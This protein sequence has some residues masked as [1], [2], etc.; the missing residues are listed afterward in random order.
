[1]PYETSRPAVLVVADEPLLLMLYARILESAGFAVWPAENGHAAV[2]RLAEPEIR[3]LFV[4]TDLKMAPEGN[5]DLGRY[6]AERLPAL[7]V[8]HVSVGPNGPGRLGT[9][10]HLGYFLPKPF[11]TD[12]LLRAVKALCGVPP[13]Y[14]VAPAG[15]SSCPLDLRSTSLGP[16]LLDSS[17][18]VATVAGVP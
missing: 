2:E 6:L 7:P 12:E 14:T 17:Y 3:P 13:A 16:E 8:L 1:M 4:L 18:E 11:R 15:V 9:D 5:G 10:E